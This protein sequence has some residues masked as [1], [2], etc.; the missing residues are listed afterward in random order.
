MDSPVQ[1]AEQ[2]IEPS[3]CDEYWGEPGASSIKQGCDVT[4][5][6]S[7]TDII[8]TG[9]ACAPAG[10]KVKELDVQLTVGD[11][12]KTIKVFGDRVWQSGVM[13]LSIS[14]PE[15]FSQ[16]P[17]VYERAFGGVHVLEKKTLSEP[18]NPAGQSF[19]GKRSKKEMAGQ[20]LPN[21]EHPKQ[22]ITIPEDTPEP[23]GFSWIAPS[24]MPR[25]QYAGTYDETWE[26]NRAPYLPEDF[27]SRYFQAAPADLISFNPITGGEQVT[28]KN[29]SPEG[30]INFELPTLEI[31]ISA[32]FSSGTE[33]IDMTLATLHLLPN[34]QQF[35]MVFNGTLGVN[36][37][38]LDCQTVN[39]KTRE[40][41]TQ[42]IKVLD[43]SKNS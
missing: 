37:R 36:K 28:I 20:P 5:L 29:M 21:L 39:I 35:A 11:I 7:A 31:D 17:L 18:R 12:E 27:D 10:Q 23:A 32:E 13:G 22:L 14:E 33:A 25:I 41:E 1:I 9:S 30:D 24:W 43:I 16:M 34:E 19:K 3:R 38:R 40:I 15:P 6:K 2:Q 4:L 26:K 42:K 8:M